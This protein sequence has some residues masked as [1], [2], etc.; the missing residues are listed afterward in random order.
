MLIIGIRL[1]KSRAQR[2]VWL[3]EEAKIDFNI[4][5]FHRQPNLLAPPEMK[6]IH[7]MGKAPIVKI[8][9]PNME[10]TVLAESGAITEYIT[11]HFAPQLAPKRYRDGCEGQL[12]GETE[13]WRRFKYFLHY[14][15]GSLM[16]FLLVAL[17]T[18][19]RQTTI[20]ALNTD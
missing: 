7:P 6:E 10:P 1:N 17:I 5:V 19:S 20:K 2:I 11:D 8:E 3:L 4:E 9:V 13:S 16:P 12:G 15:E 18:R 14:A